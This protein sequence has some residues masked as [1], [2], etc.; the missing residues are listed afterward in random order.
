MA[1]FLIETGDTALQL[2]EAMMILEKALDAY[3]GKVWQLTINS[4]GV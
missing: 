4:E 2:E 3:P 1:D